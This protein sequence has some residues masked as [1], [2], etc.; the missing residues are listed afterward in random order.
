[1]LRLH[2]DFP[3]G[4]DESVACDKSK[5]IVDAITNALKE[6]D[7]IKMFQYRLGND[8]DRVIK[9][10]LVKDEQGHVTKKKTKVYLVEVTEEEKS[11]LEEQFKQI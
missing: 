2:I 11:T 7:G 6:V 5:Q 4:E 8:N 9:N 10:Y 3:L 1:M